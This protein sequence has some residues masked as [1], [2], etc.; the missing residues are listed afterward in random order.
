VVLN[1]RFP[2]YNLVAIESNSGKRRQDTIPA[3][4]FQIA[5]E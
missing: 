3:Y 1:G 4:L 2:T 5:A